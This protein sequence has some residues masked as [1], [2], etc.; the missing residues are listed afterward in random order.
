MSAVLKPTFYVV[1]IVFFLTI[2]LTF[3]CLAYL[4]PCKPLVSVVVSGLSYEL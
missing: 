1:Y 2:F 4:H 3:F